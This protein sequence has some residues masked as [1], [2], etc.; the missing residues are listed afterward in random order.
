LYSWLQSQIGQGMPAYP[1]QLT[2]PVDPTISQIASNDYALTDFD[3]VQ[4]AMQHSIQEGQA[5]LTGQFAFAGGLAGSPFGTATADYQNQAA[6]NL[7]SVLAQMEEQAAPTRLA[8]AQSEQSQNQ[9]TLTNAYQ[10]WLRQQPQ[11]NPLLNL[12]YGA[13]NTF[14]PIYSSSYGTGGL[15]ALLSALPAIGGMSTGGGG[16]LAGDIIAGL[17]A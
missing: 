11:Y 5:S 3:A 7:Q 10:E 13:A 6:L 1:G 4:A 9:L 12:E 8:A 15:S 14:A 2:A 16:T 17:S